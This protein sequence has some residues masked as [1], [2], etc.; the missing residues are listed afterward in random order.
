MCQT[1]KTKLFR[2]TTL[3]TLD[4][5]LADA[6]QTT[7]NE[8]DATNGTRMQMSSTAAFAVL[9]IAHCAG[10]GGSDRSSTCSFPIWPPLQQAGE[11]RT[12]AC[13]C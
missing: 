2:T 10:C 6:S 8:Q 9:M 11:F 5:T 1:R 12:M 13:S 3:K 7:S 4:H